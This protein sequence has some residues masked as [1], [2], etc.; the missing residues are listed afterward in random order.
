MKVERVSVDELTLDERNARAHPEKNLRVIE[1]SLSK[2]G[3][4]KPIVVNEDNV[5]MAGNGL[6]LAARNLGWKTVQVVRTNLE[7]GLARAYALA[8][9]RAGELSEW[10]WESLARELDALKTTGFDLADIGWETHEADL[11]MAAEFTAR[12]TDESDEPADKAGR[13]VVAFTPEQSDEVRG[14]LKRKGV[15]GAADG[16]LQAL[17]AWA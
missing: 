17:R 14:H 12:T 11:V 3:Q 8:D 9:N 6:L 16:I 13:L 4:Q 5:V 7:E 1:Q 10:D 15:D 2:F